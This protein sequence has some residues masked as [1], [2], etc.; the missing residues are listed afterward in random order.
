M[1][2]Y[3]LDI[4]GES[5]RPGAKAVSVQEELDRVIPVVERLKSEFKVNISVDTS[6]PEVMSAAIVAGAD[7]INDVKALRE[8]GALKAVAQGE[9]PRLFDAYAR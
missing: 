8:P 1:V 4:G 5:T 3:W 7:M 9:Q 6:K 2:P